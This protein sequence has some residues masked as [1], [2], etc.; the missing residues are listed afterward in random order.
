[1]LLNPLDRWVSIYMA[2]KFSV[3]ISFCII[4]IQF[5]RF[6]CVS[7]WQDKCA[8]HYIGLTAAWF[9]KWCYKLRQVKTLGEN[10]KLNWKN[11]KKIFLCFL[12]EMTAQRLLHLHLLNNIT[13]L[14][15]PRKIKPDR[16]HRSHCKVPPSPGE[17]VD[18][19]CDDGGGGE[20]AGQV[21]PSQDVQAALRDG[22]IVLSN[23]QSRLG[24]VQGGEVRIGAVVSAAHL[25]Q[26]VQVDLLSVLVDDY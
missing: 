4:S 24:R 7:Y 11:T 8:L 9:K 26:L 12:W 19:D 13:L 16:I 3:K 18:E 5:V 25:S 2:F 23:R 21:D 20:R 1:M 15:C 14:S 6:N 10:M 22:W 17:W